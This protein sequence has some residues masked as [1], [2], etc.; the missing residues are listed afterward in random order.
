MPSSRRRRRASPRALTALA[1]AGAL[2]VALAGCIGA[3]APS[4]TPTPSP[5]AVPIFA[6]D[7]EALAAAEAAYGNY[8]AMINTIA[9]EDNLAPERIRTVA[10]EAWA[11][12]V[13]SLFDDLSRRGLTI[14]GET[15]ADSFKL[16][17]FVSSGWGAEVSFLVCS[18]VSNTRVIDAGG[19]DVTPPARPPRS[20]LQVTATVDETKTL[21]DD[22][23]PWSG[24]YC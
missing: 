5:S 24:E 15:T 9:R 19:T 20:A 6:S 4:P 10:S 14:E 2:A 22:E 8:L 21:I 18:D 11:S 16:L 1:S 23:A 12:N 3:P 7:E 17:E 13:E